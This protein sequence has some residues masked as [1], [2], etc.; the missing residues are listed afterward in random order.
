[1]QQAVLTVGAFVIAV[2]VLAYVLSRVLAAGGDR[3]AATPTPQTASTALV[4]GDVPAEST[5]SDP[6]GGAVADEDPAAAEQPA[7]EA[8]KAIAFESKVLEPNYT[9]EPGDTLGTIAERSG[10]TIDALVG[11]NNLPDRDG[12]SVGQTL[13]VPE[14]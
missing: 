3:V 6:E 11:L 9:V 7:P 2:V 4:A 5:V 8:T 10:N 13:I 1:M 12:L 14:S